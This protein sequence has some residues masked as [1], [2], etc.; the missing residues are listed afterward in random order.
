MSKNEEVYPEIKLP[1]DEEKF[2]LGTWVYTHYVG[3]CITIIAYLLIAIAFVSFKIKLETSH[4][5]NAI[6]IDLQQIE[7]LEKQRDELQKI[8]ETLQKQKETD[9]DKVQNRASNTNALNEQLRDNRNTNVQKLMEDA[10]KF[11][12]QME[13]NRTTYESGMAAA[14]AIKEQKNTTPL[15]FDQTSNNDER[16]DVNIKGNVTVS[17]SF[18]NPVRHAAKLTVPAYQCEGGGEVVLEVTINRRG[19]VTSTKLIS[20]GDDCMQQTAISAAK[21]SQFNLDQS[22]PSRHTGEITY[23]FIP[24]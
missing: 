10:A 21:T 13:A 1:F 12:E 5:T 6:A 11:Q 23:I 24:Q 7:K 14:K 3:I 9:W 18:S 20:G 8:V 17:Y 19:Y 4:A 15:D 16:R 2:D 22:A